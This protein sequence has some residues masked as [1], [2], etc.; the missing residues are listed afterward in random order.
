MHHKETSLFLR[1][2]SNSKFWLG[3]TSPFALFL[4]PPPPPA[5]SVW[6]VGCSHLP[7]DQPC[8]TFSSFP[9]SRPFFCKL[10]RLLLPSPA[11]PPP[12]PPPP[13]TLRKGGEGSLALPRWQKESFLLH[14]LLP[15]PSFLAVGAAPRERGGGGKGL[16][17]GRRRSDAAPPPCLAHLLFFAKNCS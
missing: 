8:K 2:F 4:L 13:H 16:R 17:R 14:G 10:V 9:F 6:S 7:S 3:D 12:P 11:A 1:T 15:G 5:M